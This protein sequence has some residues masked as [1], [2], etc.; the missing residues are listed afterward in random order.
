M[1]FYSKTQERLSKIRKIARKDQSDLGNK[2]DS[3]DDF[4]EHKF[5]IG[6]RIDFL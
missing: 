1:S 3:D 2:Y 6:E 4:T 5:K